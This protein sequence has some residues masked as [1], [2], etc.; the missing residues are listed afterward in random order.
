MRRLPILM[1][2]VIWAGTAQG[3]TILDDSYPSDAPITLD[4]MHQMVSKDFIDPRSAQYK[5][6]YVHTRY[7]G[8]DFICGWVNAKNSL[9]GYTPFAPFYVDVARNQAEVISNYDD[10][11]LGDL[12]LVSISI[13]ECRLG[14]GL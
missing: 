2:T 7:D 13:V 4:A 12:A 6:F 1:L 10:P 3:Q 5:G 8:R 14:L 9:G 11:L